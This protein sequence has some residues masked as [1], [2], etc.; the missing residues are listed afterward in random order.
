MR[1]QRNGG[2]IQGVINQLDYLQDLGIGGIY[3]NPVFDAQ[4]MHKYDATYYH[5]ID[6][7]FGPNPAADIAQFIKENPASWAW[8]SADFLFLQLIQHAHKRGIKVIIDGVFNHTGTE[9]WVFQHLLKH[10][11]KSPYR[12][13]YSVLSYDDPSTL[14]NEFDSEGW[15]GYKGLP[16]FKEAPE[17]LLK[18]IFRCLV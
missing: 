17:N 16:V 8:S 6:R 3:F 9:F 14:V 18:K 1:E 4:S 7:N 5:H 2:D 10:Q 13:L 12:H 11:E 15:W